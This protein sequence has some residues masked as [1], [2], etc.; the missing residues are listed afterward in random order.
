MKQ[1]EFEAMKEDRGEA[2]PEQGIQ[3]HSN[4]MFYLNIHFEQIQIQ[5]MNHWRE[6]LD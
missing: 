3:K 5:K 6:K 2:K 1:F 4:K